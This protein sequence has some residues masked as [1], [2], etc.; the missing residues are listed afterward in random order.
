MPPVRREGGCARSRRRESPGRKPSV[1]KPARREPV[2][3]SAWRRGQPSRAPVRTLHAAKLHAGATDAAG[4]CVYEWLFALAMATGSISVPDAA[5]AEPV[6][7]A[8]APVPVVTLPGIRVEAELD[9]ARRRAPTAFVTRIAAGRETRTLS[10]L[11]D[12]LTE[13]AGGRVTQYGGMGA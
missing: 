10:P 2:A 4:C 12:A 7:A 3:T 9:R 13:A 1:G 8:T 5:R 6:P 11:R